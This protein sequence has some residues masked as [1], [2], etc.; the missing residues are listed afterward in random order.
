MAETLQISATEKL[1]SQAL[2]ERDLC[3]L[4][5]IRLAMVMFPGFDSSSTDESGWSTTWL[6]HKRHDVA[7]RD[8]HTCP[9]LDS[10]TSIN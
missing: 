4:H 1:V 3:H 5:H 9:G 6:G 2:Q 7:L 8:M 10:G